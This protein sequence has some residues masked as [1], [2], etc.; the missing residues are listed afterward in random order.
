MRY[1]LSMLIA[2]SFDSFT[3]KDT[4]KVVRKN[5]QSYKQR[6]ELHYK[7]TWGW[8]ERERERL[9]IYYDEKEREGINSNCLS[10]E[11]SD[12]RYPLAVC[13]ISSELEFIFCNQIFAA[14]SARTKCSLFTSHAEIHVSFMQSR[15]LNPYFLR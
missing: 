2:L 15:I 1:G 9:G 7:H 3:C 13:Y 8:G 11:C 12:Q 14:P 6:G 5:L 4:Y 10:A